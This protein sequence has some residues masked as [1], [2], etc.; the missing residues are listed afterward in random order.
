MSFLSRAAALLL[1]ALSLG[2]A[3]LNASGDD[4]STSPVLKL[5]GGKWFDVEALVDADRYCGTCRFT[6]RTPEHGDATI[7]LDGRFL[8]P[9]L[10]DAHNHDAQNIWSASRSIDKNLSAGVFYSGQMCANPSAVAG[11]KGL[12]TRPST[13]DVVFTGACITSS[14]GHPLGL[15][16]R[17]QPDASPDEIREGW[18]VVD[19]MDDVE[20][21]WPGIAERHPDIIKLILVNSENFAKN[22]LDPDLFGFN[23]LDPSLVKPLVQRAHGDGVRVVV[24]TDSAAE[25]EVAVAAGADMIGHLPG[26][27][28]SR[29]M[30]PD[31]YRISDVAIA[32]AAKRGTVVMTT[33]SVAR[34]FLQAKPEHTDALR[35]VQIDNLRRLREAGVKLAIGSDLFAGTAVDE[36]LYLD[37][38][39]IAPTS[40]WIRLAVTDTPRL[41]FPD[42]KIGRFEEGME[43]SLIAYDTDP[44]SNPTILR[45]PSLIIKQ[46]NLLAVGM[47]E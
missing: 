17:D 39:A 41:L 14:D 33:A 37:A 47:V 16:M 40:E 30:Q 45:S 19:S 28:F 29:E 25:F 12:L 15:V 7:H 32:E 3:P 42:R 21:V 4:R 44:I 10:A 18:T 23:G 27:R 34:Y 5:E 43:A 13:L 1:L 6:V 26:Y 11:Y 31:D 20:R 46:G 35:S 36:I 8:L 2:L 9:P 24:H 38:L 22:R